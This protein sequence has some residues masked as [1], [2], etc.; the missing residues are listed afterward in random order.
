MSETPSLDDRAR[1]RIFAWRQA[2][3]LTQEQV[4][5]EIG[6]NAVWISRYE[7]EYFNA[8]L[9]TLTRL[10]SVFGHSL[11]E[12][13]DVSSNTVEGELTAIFRTISA[14]R[15]RIVLGIMS[16]FAEKSAQSAPK[17]VAKKSQR[18]TKPRSKRTTKPRSKN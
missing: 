12:V 9:E 15:R 6:R 5:K 13:L 10:A 16:E 18:I 11:F 2:S 3:G 4:G 7:N 17:V 1:R 8:D 14:P